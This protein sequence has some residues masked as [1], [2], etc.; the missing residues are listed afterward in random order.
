MELLKFIQEEVQRLH[1]ITLL[2]QKKNQ[3]EKKIRLLE[4]N[5]SLLTEESIDDFFNFLEFDPHKHSFAYAYYTYPVTLN[6]TMEDNGIKV[7][8]PMYGKIFKNARYKF[9]YGEVYGDAMRK[10]NPD[11][12]PGKRSGEYEKVDGYK[13][14]EMGKSGLYLPILPT[15]QKSV[16][17][18]NEDENWR[19]VDFDEIKKYFPKRTYSAAPARE[20]KQ[21]ILDRIYKISA[22]GNVW[23]NPNFKYKYLGV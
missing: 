16:Y 15:E 18:V 9:N 14:T 5:S 13:V 19:V 7:P 17:S 3:I 12:I 22:G 4:E 2:E 20:Y 1:K 23:V 11:Y 10:V 6:K 21:L 8:N